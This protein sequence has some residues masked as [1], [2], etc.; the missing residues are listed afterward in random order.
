MGE[1]QEGSE[2]VATI[3]YVHSGDE[4][5][6]RAL[7]RLGK[8]SLI[9]QAIRPPARKGLRPVLQEIRRTARRTHPLSKRRPPVGASRGPM[10]RFIGIRTISARS[11]FVGAR[12]IFDTRKF[13]GFAV[14]GK[15]TGKRA[16][17]PAAQE[18]G[19]AAANPP[20]KPQRQIKRAA[21]AAESSALA[22]FEAAFKV[23]YERV[24]ARAGFRSA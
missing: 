17:Y 21:D 13:P 9:R 4:A 8:M 2:T 6:D 15:R 20:I 22:T 11:K 23:N 3:S 14:V 12:T 24:M 10:S 16:F 19:A 7:N 5:V 18:H 1:R